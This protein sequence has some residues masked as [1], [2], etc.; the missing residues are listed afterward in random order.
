MRK[1]LE[2]PYRIL[3]ALWPGLLCTLSLH[4]AD[5]P[6]VHIESGQLQGQSLS[7]GGASFLAIPYAA[8]PVGTLRWRDPRPVAHWS[9]VR[10]ATHYAGA[11]AQ[12]PAGWNES[13]LAT[14]SEDCLYLNVWTPKFDGAA[15]LPVMV[16]IHGGAFSGGSSTD[17]VFSGERFAIKGV[18]LVSLNYRLGVFGF[19]AHPELSKTSG[20]ASSGN[21]GLLDQIAA[22]KWV[23]R[24]IGRFGGDASSITVFGQSAGGMS[25]T[26]LLA[27][28]RGHGLLD[29]AIVESGAIITPMRMQ[30]LA[31]AEAMG[32]RFAGDLDMA[33][34]RRLSAKQLLQR[35][36]QLASSRLR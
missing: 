16:W 4:A 36:Q 23:H 2:Y 33:A 5:G 12:A 14:A 21:F 35:W 30:T 18:V 11:C 25:V 15:R 17:P 27:S 24:N 20:H 9:G 7:Q 13:L 1:L 29:R 34:L 19:L 28:P 6:V 22:L 31:D 26:A 8:A 3:W 10:D 32:Q